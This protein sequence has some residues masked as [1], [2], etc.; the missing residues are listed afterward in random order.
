ML[1]GNKTGQ[2]AD[3]LRAAGLS[4]DA[5]NRIAQVLGAAVPSER[6]VPQEVDTTPQAMR[7]VN[8]NIRKHHLTNFDFRDDDP[9]YRKARV[10]SS[11][12]R[13]RPEPVSTVRAEQS[14]QQT[15]SPFNVSGGSFVTSVT[16]GDQ[17]A[18]GLNVGGPDRS[19]ATVDTTSNAII[20]KRPRAETDASGLR[21][22]I[23]ETGQELVWKLQFF[24]G[25]QE[26]LEVVTG[27]ELTARGLVVT[28]TRIAAIG[29]GEEEETVIETVSC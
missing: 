20:G 8:R 10:N 13:T 9:Y 17:V 24:G 28:K 19:L 16:R 3:A 27:V 1:D 7:Y 4:P 29:T 5:A 14:P 22:F 2:L 11:E 15:D 21:F 26:G 23:E 12:D 18:V 25:D 6:V